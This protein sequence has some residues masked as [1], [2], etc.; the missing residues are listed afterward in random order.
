MTYSII[1]S[2]TALKQLSKFDKTVRERIINTLERCRIRPYAHAKKLMGNP[3]F[4]I[5]AGDYRIIIDIREE[6]LI[7]FVIEAGHRSDIYKN[8]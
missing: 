4:R 6:K 3:Y 1:Y 8:I 2:D 7:I 5:R